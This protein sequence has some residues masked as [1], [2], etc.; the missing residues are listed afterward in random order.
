MG[1]LILQAEGR[2]DINTVMAGILV[3]TAFALALDGLV[4]RIERRLMT[5]QPKAGESEK[6]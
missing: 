2:F 5:W 3:L 1:Y 4:G 6:L